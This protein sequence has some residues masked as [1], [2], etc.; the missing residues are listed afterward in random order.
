LEFLRNN[1]RSSSD[2]KIDLAKMIA[3]N[4]ITPVALSTAERGMV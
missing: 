3:E 4:C 2:G 1:N